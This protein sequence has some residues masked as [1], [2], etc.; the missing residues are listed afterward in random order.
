MNPVFRWCC[1]GAYAGGI[2]GASSIPGVNIH[3]PG[4]FQIDKMAHMTV[5]FGFTAVLAWAIAGRGMT[6]R[7]ALAG[8]VLACVYGGTDELHQL[9]VKGRMMSAY[10]WLADAIGAGAFVIALRIGVFGWIA[11]KFTRGGETVDAG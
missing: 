3:V 2:F 10:D 11:R 7:P 5:Y 6:W 8:A 1:A 9:F 4:A